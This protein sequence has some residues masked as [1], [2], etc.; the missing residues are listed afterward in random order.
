M[1]L[2]FTQFKFKELV[3]GISYEL[4][5]WKGFDVIPNCL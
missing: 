4:D 1:K 3:F 2:R 5:L